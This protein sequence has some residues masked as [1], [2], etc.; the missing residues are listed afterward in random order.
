MTRA[1]ILFETSDGDRTHSGE[2]RIGAPAVA[3]PRSAPTTVRYGTVDLGEPGVAA[4]VSFWPVGGAEISDVRVIGDEAQVRIDD[5][6]DAPV[7]AGEACRVWV[8][9]TPRAA[10]V[11]R[12]TLRATD[13]AGRTTDV[14]LE[15]FAHGGETG[16]RVTSTLRAR[17]SGSVPIMFPGT[18]VLDTTSDFVLKGDPAHL[19]VNL[20]NARNGYGWTLHFAPP[21]GETLQ[22]GRRYT[23]ATYYSSPSDQPGLA[24]NTSRAC[25]QLA[26]EFTVHELERVGGVVTRAKV[27]YRLTCEPY[28]TG[29]LEGVLSWRAGDATPL[30]PWM[31]ASDG[32][33]PTP[34]PTVSPTATPSATATATASPTPTAT[35]SP[36]PAATATASPTTTP[37]ATAT[38][39]A[40]V[41]PSPTATATASPTTPSATAT[42]TASADPMT[43]SASATPTTTRDP[44]A[45]ATPTAAPEATVMPGPTPSAGPLPRGFSAPD[46]VRAAV[47]PCLTKARAL[48]R[49]TSAKRRA[50]AARFVRQTAR[51]HKR[52]AGLPDS[53]TRQAALATLKRHTAA[54][55]T[56]RSQRASRTAVKRAQRV[57]RT[58]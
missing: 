35:A 47:R 52:I 15:I 34:T 27:S 55:R 50:A 16:Y 38:P 51:C 44:S 22:V 6:T 54:A 18:E 33:V 29:S 1:W 12:A 10:G 58:G 30:A 36:T 23:N 17:E 39:S 31:V 32:P 25:P 42:A 40:T 49:T 7:V 48:A 37:G 43:P 20:T 41:T 26:G 5:C 13:A 57:L 8:R 19:W 9:F 56:L 14:P 3:G 53:P 21:R 4:P 45:T 24:V 2:V 46:P 11:R 28:F